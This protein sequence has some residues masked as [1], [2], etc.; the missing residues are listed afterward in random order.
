MM[1]AISDGKIYV[2]G[3]WNMGNGK[4]RD[5][6]WYRHGLVADLSRSPIKW[7]KLPET[8]Q[9]VRAHATEVFGGKLYVAGGINGTGTLNTIRV[10]DLESGKWTDG[11][12]FPGKVV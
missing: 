1:S 4:A 12:C 2:T 3:G 5:Q 8:E 6:Q 9:V 10:L 7:E 11:H